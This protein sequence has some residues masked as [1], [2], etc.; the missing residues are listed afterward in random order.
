MRWSPVIG[1]LLVPYKRGSR[2]IPSPFHHMGI[3]GEACDL[4]EGPPLIMLAP[5]SLQNCEK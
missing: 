2:G 1:F 3:Q 5:S 4:E